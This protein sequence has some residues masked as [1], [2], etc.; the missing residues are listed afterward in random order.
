MGI[1]NMKHRNAFTLIELMIVVG[2]IGVLTA[3]AIPRYGEMIEKAN[4]GATL[5]NIAAIR[6][7]I[8]IYYSAYAML[9]ADLDTKNEQFAGAMGRS[10]PGVK[11]RFPDGPNSPYGNGVTVGTAIPSTSGSGWYYDKKNAYVY[12]NSV[13]NDIYS[14]SYSIY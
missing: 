12:I 5:G 14:K 10:I 1:T 3:V 11:V 4:H 9:P 2:I 7:A 8:S 13:E 6:S